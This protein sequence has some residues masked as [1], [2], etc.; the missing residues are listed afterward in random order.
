MKDKAW[1]KAWYGTYAT[2]GGGRAARGCD[3]SGGGIG[4]WVLGM[5]VVVVEWVARDGNWVVEDGDRVAKDGGLGCG[6]RE[7]EA[8][9]CGIEAGRC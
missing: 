4:S 9:K 8:G 3:G 5:A 2:M 7:V 1:D 6:W